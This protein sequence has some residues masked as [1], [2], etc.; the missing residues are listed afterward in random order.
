[1]LFTTSI[2]YIKSDKLGQTNCNEFLDNF[3]TKK[4]GQN[5]FNYLLCYVQPYLIRWLWLFILFIHISIMTKK[6]K[7]KP[8]QSPLWAFVSS[9]YPNVN[10]KHDKWV[11]ILSNFQNLKFPCANL[12]PLLKSFWQWFWSGFLNFSSF[13]ATV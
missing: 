11:K 6:S 13:H 8:V 5:L 2:R 9:A 7:F 12:N 3:L 4:A 1:M 10:T